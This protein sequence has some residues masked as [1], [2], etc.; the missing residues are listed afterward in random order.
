M[1]S[2]ASTCF[3]L[4]YVFY[5]VLIAALSVVCFSFLLS[6]I[7]DPNE[8]EGPLRLNLAVITISVS[9]TQG[10]RHMGKANGRLAM[11]E[12]LTGEMPQPKTKGFNREGI[13]E[14]EFTELTRLVDLIIPPSTLYFF[15][16]FTLEG[17]LYIREKGT[18]PLIREDEVTLFGTPYALWAFPLWNP[19]S[20][21]L[22]ERL[23]K[24]PDRLN[25]TL[26]A[27][28]SAC[29]HV[30]GKEWSPSIRVRLY[31]GYYSHF[32]MACSSRYVKLI[33]DCFNYI[34]QELEAFQYALNARRARNGIAEMID[35]RKLWLKF[36]RS[37]FEKMVTRTHSWVSDRVN[38][39]MVNG[40][41]EYDA[42]AD[43]NRAA[44]AY[45]AAK[46]LLKSWSDL[47]RTVHLCDWMIIMP[48]DGFAGF[49]PSSSDTKVR[50]ELAARI[51]TP[52][53]ERMEHMLENEQAIHTNRGT[54]NAILKE[55][56]DMNDQVR[57]QLRSAPKSFGREN[58]I[59]T[60][61][62]RTKWSLSHSGP[63]DQT[64][65]D[66]MRSSRRR[67]PT[68][69]DLASGWKDL[70]SGFLKIIDKT[71]YDPRLI[72]KQSPGYKNELK[73]LGCLVIDDLYPLIVSLVERPSDLWLYAMLQPDQ[74]YVGPCVERQ[75]KEWERRSGSGGVSSRH[76]N[77]LLILKRFGGIITID[78]AFWAEFD[79]NPPGKALCVLVEDKVIVMRNPL[80]IVRWKMGQ[81]QI[82]CVVGQKI[83]V[84]RKTTLR[85]CTP[86]LITEII[87]ILK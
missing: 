23:L 76:R 54:I 84:L 36:V 46:D 39:V 47:N 25:V 27:R 32:H 86:R 72:A 77:D 57:L 31:V 85:R 60:I 4:P 42:V 61:R 71:A 68:L 11:L 63:Q 7:W 62:S 50:E 43:A 2:N 37:I 80:P 13:R 1:F 69:S 66:G 55:S 18:L 12:A 8:G 14:I 3:F 34:G 21:S 17:N 78:R 33:R 87:V 59:S 6:V 82:S 79:W 45:Q 30:S 51:P 10:R 19:A 16:D 5:S 74:V 52:L 58:C 83:K 38:E 49:F 64:E 53:M 41:A 65:M 9:K 15:L 40:N 20:T 44:N 24:T 35:M 56:K 22:Q 81:S 48:M 67:M 29:V 75:E 70:M 73:I 28:I 26:K